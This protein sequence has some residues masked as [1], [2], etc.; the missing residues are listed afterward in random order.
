MQKSAFPSLGIRDS[1]TAEK[2]L[3]NARMSFAW[4]FFG[5]NRWKAW[6]IRFWALLLN[7]EM[8]VTIRESLLKASFWIRFT[9][10]KTSGSTFLFPLCTG[11]GERGALP[12]CRSFPEKLPG[13]SGMF[14]WDALFACKSLAGA[15]GGRIQGT[16]LKNL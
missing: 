5:Q 7:G 14:G 6:I 2:I 15:F 13:G 3:R 4:D 12:R 8:R 9:A 11:L 1:L 16:D 10:V